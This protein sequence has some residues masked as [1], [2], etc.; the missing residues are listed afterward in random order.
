MAGF[1]AHIAQTTGC[2]GGKVL[3]DVSTEVEGPATDCD[4]DVSVASP[5]SYKIVNKGH[6]NKT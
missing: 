3:C 2:N 1:V 4:V 5:S 6:S